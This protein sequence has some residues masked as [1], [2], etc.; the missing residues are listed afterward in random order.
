DPEQS[1]PVIATTSE[2]MTTG[3]DAQTC[4]VIALD[5]EIGSMTKFKQIVGRGTR[6]NEE[7]GKLYFTILDFRN[8]TDLFADKAFDGDPERIKVVKGDEPVDGD[9]GTD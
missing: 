5:T 1:Y 7:F 4:K 9:F 6:V 8:V 2:L 3:V